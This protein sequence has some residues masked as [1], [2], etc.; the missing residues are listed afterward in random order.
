MRPPYALM[1]HATG[2]FISFPSQEITVPKV[3]IQLSHIHMNFASMLNI[4]YVLTVHLNSM[5]QMAIE[6]TLWCKYHCSSK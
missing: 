1:C 6:N 3:Q 4:E 2:L 5:L